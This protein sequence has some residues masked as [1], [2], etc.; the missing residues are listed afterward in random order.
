MQDFTD[1]SI[2]STISPKY[3]IYGK[4]ISLKKKKF[5]NAFYGLCFIAPARWLTVDTK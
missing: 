5:S 4:Y 1:N 2:R 3:G